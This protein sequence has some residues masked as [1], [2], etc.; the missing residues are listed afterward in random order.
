MLAGATVLHCCAEIEKPVEHMHDGLWLSMNAVV[1]LK[2]T[3]G[4]VCKIRCLFNY[5]R[6][7]NLNPVTT[8]VYAITAMVTFYINA[9]FPHLTPCHAF[10]GNGNP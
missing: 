8:R 3:V 10:I 1:L 6:Q 7:E 9:S 4:D 5:F 2:D